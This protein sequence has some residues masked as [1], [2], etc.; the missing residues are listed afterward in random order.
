M[1][2]VRMKLLYT[3]RTANSVQC[4][5]YVHCRPKTVHLDTLCARLVS[6]PSLGSTAHSTMQVY[7]HTNTSHRQYIGKMMA[8]L[9][10][11]KSKIRQRFLILMSFQTIENIFFCLE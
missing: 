3:M 5:V 4:S 9:G 10:T 1:G 6:L 7:Q 8:V 11:T 2:I